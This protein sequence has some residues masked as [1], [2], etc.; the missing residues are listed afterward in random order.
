MSGI[1]R[2]QPTGADGRGGGRASPPKWELRTALTEPRPHGSVHP[3]GARCRTRCRCRRARRSH[4]GLTLHSAYDEHCD[5][6]RRADYFL[7]E[8]GRGVHVVPD[9]V[10]LRQH[11]EDRLLLSPTRPWLALCISRPA[12]GVLAPP[13]PPLAAAVRGRSV[14]WCVLRSSATNPTSRGSASTTSRPSSCGPTASGS[15]TTTCAWRIRWWC[16]GASLWSCRSPRRIEGLKLRGIIDRL[17][18]RNGEL[19]VTDYKT[20]RPPSVNWELRQPVRACVLAMPCRAQVSLDAGGD[21][22]SP[23]HW[24]DH[25]GDAIR[26]GHPVRSPRER[27]QL[28]RPFERRLRDGDFQ[29]RPTGLRQSAAS[30]RGRRAFGGDPE[31][32]HLEAPI[33]L[34]SPRRERP[35]VRHSSRRVG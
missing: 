16:G 26:T 31:R 30:A 9:A 22:A 12:A 21:P 19:V 27:L 35:A 1:G 14:S 25:R 28:G 2:R 18:L 7:A 29:P 5:R 15:S 6:V 34:G 24:R 33:V 11:R 8:S 32:A 3:P 17:E 23:E 20:G 13:T 4:P 10:P